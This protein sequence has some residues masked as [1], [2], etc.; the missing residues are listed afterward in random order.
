MESK[1][2]ADR[3]AA[4]AVVPVGLSGSAFVPVERADEPAGPEHP[5]ENL[6]FTVSIVISWALPPVI[7]KASH[8]LYTNNVHSMA[9]AVEAGIAPLYC[10]L[11]ALSIVGLAVIMALNRRRMASFLIYTFSI[12]ICT[13]VIQ[14]VRQTGAA[15]TT[16]AR[17][18]D[19]IS[20]SVAAATHF[21]S[22]KFADPLTG[23]VIDQAVQLTL[24]ETAFCLFPRYLW[25]LCHAASFGVCME[26]LRQELYILYLQLTASAECRAA[27]E[28]VAAFARACCERPVAARDESSEKDELLGA[29][30]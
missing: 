4:D 6:Q 3:P 20:Q 29:M 21:N 14:A 25:V 26:Y 5:L 10:G 17:A 19:T 7:A 11:I 28:R 9:A 24:A 12:V 30:V 23:V 18:A 13:F 2:A 1:P 27:A 15:D 16:R 22:N 8:L